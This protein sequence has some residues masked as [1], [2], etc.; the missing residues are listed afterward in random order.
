MGKTSNLIIGLII[1]LCYKFPNG[2]W[3]KKRL[4]NPVLY[5]PCTIVNRCHVNMAGLERQSH[6]ELVLH[7]RRPPAMLPHFTTPPLH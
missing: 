4:P 7:V 1:K 2:P 6:Q 3:R 5:R